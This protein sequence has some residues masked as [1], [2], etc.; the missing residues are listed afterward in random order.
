M[1]DCIVTLRAFCIVCS[2]RIE[3]Q[4]VC[5]D[6][7]GIEK[8]GKTKS[9]LNMKALPRDVGGSSGGTKKPHLGFQSGRRPIDT[10]GHR[11]I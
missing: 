6:A 9:Q 5:D 8:I 11:G 2:K 1:R 3:K 10:E 7:L 4:F